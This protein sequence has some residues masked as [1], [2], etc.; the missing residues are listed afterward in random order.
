MLVL[1]DF[2]IVALISPVITVIQ[3]LVPPAMRTTSTG[4]MVTCNNL[5]GMALGPLVLGA[6]SDRFDLPTAMLLVSFA[7]ILAAAAFFGAVTLYDREFGA[8]AA[9]LSP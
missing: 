1:G 4:A 8:K 9:I 2:V 5:F 6:L 7:P 3:E